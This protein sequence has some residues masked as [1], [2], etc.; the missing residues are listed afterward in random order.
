MPEL[1]PPG[2]RPDISKLSPDVM[3]VRLTLP[4]GFAPTN[5]R[6]RATRSR[7]LRSPSCSA[8]AGLPGAVPH[9][10]PTRAVR[11]AQVYEEIGVMVNGRWKTD[12]ELIEE[13]R[14]IYPGWEPAAWP[15][16]ST[17]I[18][19]MTGADYL[20]NPEVGGDPDAWPLGPPQVLTVGEI[21]FDAIAVSA[22]VKMGDP[23]D[24]WADYVGGAPANVAAALA[25]LG[26]PAAFVGSVGDD[27]EGGAI[28]RALRDAQLP[29]KPVQ[30]VQGGQTRRVYV[31]RDAAG[32]RS[33]AGFPEAPDAFADTKFDAAAFD[34]TLLY[35]AD[36][37]VTGAAA[38][39]RRA[40]VAPPSAP[41][42]TAPGRAPALCRH[43]GAGDARDA[44][45]SQAGA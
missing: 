7:I 36:Y 9:G 19:R 4:G 1:Q 32:D 28:L 42:L 45:V 22:D 11:G 26:T 41:A 6:C 39:P 23:D 31:T 44:V 38:P 40:A 24:R 13:W 34:G 29:T 18:T 3:K 27:K 43:A 17:D 20:S 12:E 21:L 2:V 33:F 10:R 25:K 5:F 14:E 16:G 35:A 15:L 8:P 30:V 37:L